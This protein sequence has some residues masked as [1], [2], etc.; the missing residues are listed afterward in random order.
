[1]SHDKWRYHSNLINLFGEIE[2]STN[3]SGS[4]GSNFKCKDPKCPKIAVKPQK[5]RPVVGRSR[6]N[7]AAPIFEYYDSYKWAHHS[8]PLRVFVQT[9]SLEGC[10]IK[11]TNFKW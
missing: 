11:T 9:R 2:E 7:P 3:I 10:K 1:M 6:A 8:H 5:V 4:L